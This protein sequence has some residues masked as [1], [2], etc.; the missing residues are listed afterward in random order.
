MIVIITHLILNEFNLCSHMFF[1]AWQIYEFICRGWPT[2]KKNTDQKVIGDDIL[3][4][5]LDRNLRRVY[6]KNVESRINLLTRGIEINGVSFQFYGS[7]SCAKGAKSSD[8]KNTWNTDLWP[9]F[10]S[11]RLCRS[12][13]AWQTWRQ[14]HVIQKPLI[15]QAS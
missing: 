6:L 14:T 5:Q 3:C 8:K 4:V 2:S 12:W 7:N 10:V 11:S 9:P 13:N 1:E 15:W